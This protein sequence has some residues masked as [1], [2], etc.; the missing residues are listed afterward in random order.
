M[1]TR[2]NN[3]KEQTTVVEVK[4]LC[5]N[6]ISLISSSIYNGVT[7]DAQLEIE[8]VS[9]TNLFE[10]LKKYSDDV[11]IKE[12]L[13]N[14]QRVYF[15]KHLGVRK[16]VNTLMEK[17]AK[18]NFTLSEILES[19][20]NKLENTPEVLLYEA[21]ISAISGFNYLPTVNT[22]LNAITSKVSQYKND[23]DI[24]KIIEIMKETRS[25][26]LLPLIEDVVDNYLNNKNEQN[27]S[28]LK[29]TLVKFSY[30][31]FIRDIINIVS[32][33]ATQLQLEYANAECDITEKL[34]SPIL[35]LGENE[36]LFNVKGTYYVKKGNNINKI[37][38]E[39]ILNLNESFKNL[40]EVINLPSVE[41]T[42]KDIKVYVGDD[43]AILNENE[44]YVNGSLFTKNQINESAEVAKWGGNA[45]FFNILNIL[46]E[47]FDE[48]AELDFVK[49]VELKENG[50]YAADVFKLRDNIFITTFDPLNNKATFYRNINPIQAE[51]IMME[52]M[53]FDVSKTFEDILPNKEKILAEIDEAKKEYSD[54]IKLLEERIEQFL[55]EVSP[56]TEG[57]ISALQEELNDV[58]NDYKNYI[59]E[60]EQYINVSENLNITVQDDT[61][62]KSYTVVVPTGAMAAKGEEGTGEVGS[63]AEGDEFGTEVGMLNLPS[64]D[65]TGGASSAV[66]FDDDQTE[67]L[68]DQPSDDQD[69][70]ELGADDIEAYADKVDAEAELEKPEETPA[71]GGEIAPGAEVP[72]GGEDPELAPELGANGE[73]DTAE[74]D[75]GLKTPG[76]G[77]E[78]P[79]E[80]EEAP[81]EGVQSP[82][83]EVPG[84]EKKKEEAVGAPEKNL[85]RT[86]FEKDKNP[87]DLDQPKKIKKV[88][89]KRPKKS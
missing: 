22:E 35:Y 4:A 6:T 80:G 86:N 24:S 53:R 52:H 26:Y 77:E 30:D 50:N 73:D 75:L 76:E 27:K 60:V 46:R 57:V 20:R 41:V 84:E 47:N 51:K 66:T 40:C 14:Q 62:G 32:L 9:L 49:R 8:R 59:N 12:W 11:L 25:N 81:P 55:N 79:P 2:I 88:F 89:L 7:P 10:E 78:A 31:P 1:I 69:K 23:V 65:T 15:V 67:L 85:E 3:L 5:E 38:K 74:L 42:K 61:S 19:F 70:V 54:Y 36:A 48:I 43:N 72:Q 71:E 68:S 13:N 64:P 58:K 39:N 17:E 45:E 37:K 63:G 83:E 56:T 21:F 18:F 82:S 16:A 28:F 29:E 44:T 34:F 33:D 87:G